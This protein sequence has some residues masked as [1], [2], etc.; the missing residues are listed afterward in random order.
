MRRTTTRTHPNRSR[1]KSTSTSAATRSSTKPLS[2]RSLLRSPWIS[3]AIRSGTEHQSHTACCLL[4]KL[5]NKQRLCVYAFSVCSFSILFLL[6]KNCFLIY[7]KRLKTHWLVNISIY[8]FSCG[9]VITIFS[10]NQ[11]LKE[12]TMNQKQLRA[13]KH[14]YCHLRST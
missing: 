10:G 9:L 13:E 11:T 4:E 1:E 6:L 2:A 8:I 14:L 7:H 3:R 12:P 5:M